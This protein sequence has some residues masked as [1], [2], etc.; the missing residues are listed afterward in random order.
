[1]PTA[2]E[3]IKKILPLLKN[4]PVRKAVL[5]GSYARDEQCKDSDIDILEVDK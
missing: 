3:L 4:Y 5:F 2:D 1:M